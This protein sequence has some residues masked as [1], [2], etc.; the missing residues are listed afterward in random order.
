M[1]IITVKLH[2]QEAMKNAE[3]YKTKCKEKQSEIDYAYT[4]G[5][6]AAYKEIL[7]DIEKEKYR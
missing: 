2:T 4:V 1:G 3:K 6:I 5:K 7:N